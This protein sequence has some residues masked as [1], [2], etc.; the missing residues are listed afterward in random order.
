MQ[1]HFDSFE[2]NFIAQ[3]LQE[4]YIS[5]VYEP[6]LGGR[7][8]LT[9]IDLGANI[10][11]FSMYASKFAKKIIAVEPSQYIFDFLT[12]N[13]ENDD[14]ITRVK[15]AIGAENGK[16]E[17]FGS[18]V[19]LTMFSA[20]KV[21]V[22]TDKSEIVQKMGLNTLLDLH[23]LTHVDFLKLDIEGSEFEV[24]AS[25][26]FMKAAPKIDCIM[27][28]IHEW[29]GR[30]PRQCVQS[31]EEAGFEVELLSKSPLLFLAKRIK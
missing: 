27:G 31:M 24:L 1:L 7:K 6:M 9:I 16:M 13:T 20:H 8:D 11:L 15:A 10:G 29:V 25:D 26:E 12:K 19:N 5:G 14:K 22:H 18:D 3:I 23:S 17:L 28:E 2:R 4:I 21:N 30:N